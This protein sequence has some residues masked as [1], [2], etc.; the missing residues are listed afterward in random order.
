MALAIYGMPIAHGIAVGKAHIAEHTQL[1]IAEHRIKPRQI[2]DEIKRFR[3][4]VLDARAELAR[5]AERI[6]ANTPREVFEFVDI[7]RLMLEDSSLSEAPESIIKEQSCNAEWALQVQRNHL[8]TVFDDMDDPYL[9]SRLEDVDQVIT[10]IQKFL[11][12]SDQPRKGTAS[13]RGLVL[14]ADELSPADLSLIYYE[15]VAGLVVEHGGPLSHT[16]IL[17]RGL[18]IPTVMGIPHARQMLSEGEPLIVDGDRGVVVGQPGRLIRQHYRARLK[19]TEARASSLKRLRKLPCQTQDGTT[20]LL[21]ANVDLSDDARLLHDAGADGIGLFRTEYLFMNQTG[22][23]SEDEQYRA[24]REI[25]EAMKG[26]PVTIRTLDAGADKPLPSHAQLMTGQNPA[27]GLRAIRLCLNDA[28]L[29]RPQLRAILRASAH[30]PV[31][32]LIPMLSHSKELF[33]VKNL[34]QAVATELKQTGIAIGDYQ[35]GGMIEVPAA[36]LS[37]HTFAKNL[38]FLSIGTN[39]LIQYTLAIDRIDDQVGYLYDPLHPAVLKLLQLTLDAAKRVGTPVSLCGEMAGEPA[40]TRLLL[41]LGLRDFSMSPSSLLEVKDVVQRT[42]LDELTPL[43][44]RIM[45]STNPQRTATLLR[46]LNA[47]LQ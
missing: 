25:V 20:V 17:A 1:E 7:H 15:G 34:V 5:I 14:V 2:E 26:K 44:R 46:E 40:H 23:P 22:T 45:R 11:A 27:L 43:L 47:T 31:K 18:K 38:D 28:D 8:A 37:A 4:A 24:Y 33:Q 19:A 16:A 9:A 39:D 42:H 12:A 3:R 35:L 13:Y 21:Q 41:G 10:R 36:A 32:I 6:P 29:F 30:G